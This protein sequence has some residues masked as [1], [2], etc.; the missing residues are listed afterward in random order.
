MKR[1]VF[2]QKD[3]L[4]KKRIMIKVKPKNIE[5]P[6]MSE[7]GHLS[8][9]RDELSNEIDTPKQFVDY[10]FDKPKISTRKKQPFTCHKIKKKQNSFSNSPNA[11]SK[12]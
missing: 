2:D 10:T 1:V 12:S 8:T 11:R 4:V 3:R 9:E 5:M 7:Q 6:I